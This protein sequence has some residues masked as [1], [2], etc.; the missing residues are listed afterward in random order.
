MARYK[1]LGGES[2]ATGVSYQD[3]YAAPGEEIDFPDACDVGWMIKAGIIAMVPALKP[4]R[5]KP[6]E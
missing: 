1:V 4:A 6:E 5:A 3:T 2:G